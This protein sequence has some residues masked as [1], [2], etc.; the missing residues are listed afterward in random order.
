M[1]HRIDP[2][3][4]INP[5][6]LL[7]PRRTRKTI[8]DSRNGYLRDMRNGFL[9]NGGESYFVAEDD[10]WWFIYV[11]PQ[12]TLIIVPNNNKFVENFSWGNWL[13]LFYKFDSEGRACPY[14]IV[15]ESDEDPFYEITI[16]KSSPESI[17]MKSGGSDPLCRILLLLQ[18]E[19]N[20]L[21]LWLFNCPPL[22]SIWLE[23]G[24]GS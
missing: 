14:R 9:C 22:L 11:G 12:A 8:F 18:S 24:M 10:R 4:P 3:R 19:V 13:E 23:S 21:F 15:P 6:R 1:S 20:L 17:S 16:I 2:S 7:L 5:E